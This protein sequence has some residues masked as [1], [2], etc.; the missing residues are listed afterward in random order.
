M[1]IWKYL[2]VATFLVACTGDDKTAPADAKQAGS[3]SDAQV[4]APVEVEVDAAPAGKLVI[5]EVQAD[6]PD[7][8]ELYNGTNADID[9][10]TYYFSDDGGA[11]TAVALTG[12]IAAGGYKV[13]NTV[14]DFTVG[15]NKT[16][17]SVNLYSDAG[18]T[19]VDTVTWAAAG[20][21]TIAV[22]TYGRYPNGTGDFAKMAP[23][24]GTANTAPL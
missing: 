11:A 13:L 1:K 10:S 17:D 19:V 6:N 5:N 9:L 3:G 21:F 20:N 23:S 12:T 18:I 22:S 2:S 16:A 8:V 24:N 14:T 4:D 7:W 15:I